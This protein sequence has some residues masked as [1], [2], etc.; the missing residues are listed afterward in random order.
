MYS[1]P[2]YCSN[3]QSTNQL[4]ANKPVEGASLF[5]FFFFSFFGFLL[6]W[7]AMRYANKNQHCAKLEEGQK[8][9]KTVHF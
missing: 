3:Q 6:L 4:T 5:F 2:P 9:L 8:L 1:S 7:P